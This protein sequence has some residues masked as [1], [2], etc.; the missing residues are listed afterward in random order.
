M[1]QSEKDIKEELL[2]INQAK[3]NPEVF[4]FLYEKY[5]KYIFLFI[6]KR[7]ED[8]HTT[9]DLTS[10]VF[11]KALI[12]LPQYKSKGVPFSAWL[13]RIASNQVNAF[14]RQ[15]KNKRSISL[16]EKHIELLFEQ[17]DENLPP[18]NKTDTLIALLNHLDSDDVELL[19][20]RFFEERPF[21]EVGFILGI[22]ENL[23][24]TK[25]Y[26]LLQKMKKLLLQKQ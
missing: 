3:K 25:T 8:Q 22:S 7:V 19:E 6:N 23:A 24:K 26:R 9:S 20:L 13:F 4:G 12:A 18:K 11:L 10:Q 16:E 2:I 14:F 17:V 1:H 5:Y 15:S 21:K